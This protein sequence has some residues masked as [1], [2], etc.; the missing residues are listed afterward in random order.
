M[1]VTTHYP[2]TLPGPEDHTYPSPNPTAD[3]P[4]SPRKT[5]PTTAKIMALLSDLISAAELMRQT[6]TSRQ[7]VYQILARLMRDGKA[8]RVRERGLA[9]NYL[10]LRTDIDLEAR[11]SDYRRVLT[12]DAVRVLSSLGADSVHAISAV[13]QHVGI[14]YDRAA[15]HVER[16]SESGLVSKLRFGR[17]KFVSITPLGL[18]HP[19]WDAA[20]RKAPEG[21]IG[22]NLGRTRT[23]FIAALVAWEE[24][25]AI[26]LKRAAQASGLAPHKLSSGYIMKLLQQQNLVEQL[27]YARGTR[28][29]YRLTETGKRVADWLGKGATQLTG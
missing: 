3:A 7:R 6:G 4:P 21:D 24:G 16:L 28:P 13:A 15:A 27:D 12:C 8:R 17:P 14:R 25:R 10:W 2:A 5:S 9:P 22:K 26:D 11:L 29:R 23:G 19:D 18:E 1:S 20:A